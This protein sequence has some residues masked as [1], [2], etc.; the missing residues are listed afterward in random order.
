M[1]IKDER[2]GKC[3]LYGINHSA[4]V[5]DWQTRHFRDPEKMNWV[6]RH[7]GKIAGL[8]V[9]YQGRSVQSQGNVDYLNITEFLENLP[10]FAKSLLGGISPV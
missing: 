5:A 8:A 7:V 3:F 10:E 1:I 4:A 2:D 6:K 9:L